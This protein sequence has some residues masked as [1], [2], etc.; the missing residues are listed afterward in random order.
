MDVPLTVVDPTVDNFNAKQFRTA[1]LSISATK[2]PKVIAIRLD[3]DGDNPN[4]EKEIEAEAFLVKSLSVYEIS[5]VLNCFLFPQL[6]CTRK[7][8][9]ALMSIPVEYTPPAGG[10]MIKEE[11]FNLGGGGLFIRSY[12][13]PVPGKILDL[14]LYLPDG[15][16]PVQC[17]AKVVF[18]KAYYFDTTSI[19]PPGMGL[20]F[21]EIDS[22]DILRIRRLVHSNMN[23]LENRHS[24][25]GSLRITSSS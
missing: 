23:E 13:P 12:E 14:T 24:Q 2:R 20:C 25:E 1:L 17:S 4:A 11:S 9:R 5:F 16:K 10:K 8:P 15:G 22:K 3:P 19:I 6:K 7:H 18:C 21:H